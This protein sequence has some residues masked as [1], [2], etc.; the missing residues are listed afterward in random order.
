MAGWLICPLIVSLISQF[1][2]NQYMGYFFFV[3]DIVCMYKTFGAG[4][5]KDVKFIDYG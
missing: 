2:G 3:S 1:H 5:P 4:N